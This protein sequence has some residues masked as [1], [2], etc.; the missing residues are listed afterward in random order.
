MPGGKKAG[1]KIAG[2]TRKTNCEINRAAMPIKI[3][4]YMSMG[5]PTVASAVGE[6]S[7]LIK[8]GV[9]GFLVKPE[10]ENDLE[11]TLGY[12]IQNLDFANELGKRAAEE[13]VKNYSKTVA[14]EKIGKIL[15]QE[16]VNVD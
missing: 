6:V 14:L 1:N 8:D 15:Q 2:K 12:I 3:Y 13:I 11:K 5:L 10:D 9:N 16:F 4:E 7:D